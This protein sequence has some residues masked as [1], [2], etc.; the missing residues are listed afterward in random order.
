MTSATLGFQHAKNFNIANVS[1]GEESEE[2][3]SVLRFNNSIFA[4]VTLHFDDI[5]ML[6]D[7]QVLNACPIFF[8]ASNE[9]EYTEFT[10]EKY[11]K[12]AVMTLLS[13]LYDDGVKFDQ[14]N[15]YSKLSKE[16]L[17][18]Q[19][20]DPVRHCAEVF[21]LADEYQLPV[22]RSQAQAN[23][24]SIRRR[25][26]QLKD[27]LVTTIINSKITDIYNNNWFLDMGMLDELATQCL[28]YEC[29]KEDD[30]HWMY[31]KIDGKWAAVFEEW[32]RLVKR[33]NVVDPGMTPIPM[34]RGPPKN[35][36]DKW[37][38]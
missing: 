35:E 15:V 3:P 1:T 36:V 30:H 38:W 28:E 34:D 37:T 12:N 14:S 6:C 27:N 18:P 5:S 20:W 24:M 26:M 8:Q 7:K 29:V 17:F 21:C 4:D 11:S 13:H 31:R 25:A 32:E 9:Q 33:L 22:L 23:I 2:D 19:I 10:I 16:D